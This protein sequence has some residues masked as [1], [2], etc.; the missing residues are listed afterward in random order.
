MKQSY[1]A[2]GEWYCP[3]GCHGRCRCYISPEAAAT[4]KLAQVHDHL[5]EDL[6]GDPGGV[7]K[8]VPKFVDVIQECW[9]TAEAHGFHSGRTFGDACTLIHSEIS[10]A[11]EAYRVDGAHDSHSIDGKPEGTVAELADAV[12]R[13]FDTA[14][15]DCGQTAQSFA[16][17]I[18]EKMRYNRT[19]PWMHGKII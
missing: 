18:L 3:N 10:E 4:V 8:G 11:Y 2:K 16:T 17:T 13:L 1:N 19:R 5:Y 15:F 7:P 14:L 9:D 12:I 6:T